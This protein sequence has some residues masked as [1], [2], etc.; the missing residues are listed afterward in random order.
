[1]TQFPNGFNF[2]GHVSG[3]F[4][5]A[6]AARSTLGWLLAAHQ[7]LCLR[8]VSTG[9][10]RTGQD[11]RYD[12]L[13]TRRPWG[14][15]FDA[16]LFH[17]NPPEMDLCL[18][19]E[20]LL[21]PVERRMNLMVPFWELPS[22]PPLWCNVLAAMDL[23][24]APTRFVQTIV[25]TNIP[26]A[27]SLHFPITIPMPQD[28][29]PD[30][31]RFGLPEHGLVFL[32]AFDAAS[33][34]QRKNPWAAIEAFQAAFTEQE[35]VH[36]VIKLTNSNLCFDLRPELDRLRRVVD[37]DPRVR[38]YDQHFARPDLT[39]FYAS[40]DVLISLHR[41]EGLGLIL[42][43]MMSLGKPVIATAWSGNMDFTN[44]DNAC[45]VDY[46]MVLVR[47]THTVYQQETTRAA[48]MWADPRVATAATWMRRLYAEPR[49]R[50][51]LGGQAAQDMQRRAEANRAGL[52]QEIQRQLASPEVQASHHLRSRQLFQRRIESVARLATSPRALL[53]Q[54]RSVAGR[55]MAHR[56]RQT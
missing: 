32:S 56:P 16:N 46:D 43:E 47:A 15:P 48:P 41:T 2:F 42:M 8:D 21:L 49:L 4:G 36:L 30:R 44:L 18:A 53:R 11:H 26:S 24:L 33:D 35:N 19:R 34:I 20:W 17:I 12:F 31:A 37:T 13:R 9:D 6:V 52:L 50:A 39:S 7:P 29:R 23:V 28:P 1:L 55:A 27:R 38:L 54:F 25:D 22:L 14:L 51:R 45:L 10:H 40:C 3:D 5:L